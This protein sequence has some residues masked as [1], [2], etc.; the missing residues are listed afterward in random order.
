MSSFSPFLCNN[1]NNGNNKNYRPPSLIKLQGQL[2]LGFVTNKVWGGGGGASSLLSSLV[3]HTKRRV[4]IIVI[5]TIVANKKNGGQWVE[6]ETPSLNFF[7][8][9]QA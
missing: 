4:I 2:G 1:D 7:K 9:F 5:S 6:L 8:F 3:A